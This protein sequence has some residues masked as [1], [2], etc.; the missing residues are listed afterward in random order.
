MKKTERAYD[1]SIQEP[2]IPP[3]ATAKEPMILPSATARPFEL[4]PQSPSTRARRRRAVRITNSTSE[5][6]L[7]ESY[8]PRSPTSNYEICL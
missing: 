7:A 4:R 5:S 3:S 6:D 2:M 8:D 1:P